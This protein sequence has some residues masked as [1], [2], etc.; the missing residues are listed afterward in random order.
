M[1]KEEQ[2]PKDKKTWGD[3]VG[4]TIEKAG[5]KIAD[6][7]APTLGQRVHDLGDKLETHHKNSNHPHKI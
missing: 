1:K 6:L 2:N 4:G 3:R 7:G 5:H